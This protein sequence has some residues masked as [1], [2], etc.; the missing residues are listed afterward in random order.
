VGADDRRPAQC[1]EGGARWASAEVIVR[2][3]TNYYCTARVRKW[4]TSADLRVAQ[5][6][7]YS[8]G[9]SDVPLVLSAQPFLTPSGPPLGILPDSSPLKE[10]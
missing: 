3:S 6:G 10:L 2:C 5:S 9:T 4:P 1:G 7:P 8:W